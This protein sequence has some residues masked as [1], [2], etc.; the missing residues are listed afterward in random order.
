MQINFFRHLTDCPTLGFRAI[1]APPLL[2]ASSPSLVCPTKPSWLFPFLSTNLI[3]FANRE[4]SEIYRAKAI[5]A[6][7]RSR[8]NSCHS[9]PTTTPFLRSRSPA[10]PISHFRSKYK[11]NPAAQFISRFPSSFRLTRS[12]SRELQ[13]YFQPLSFSRVQ[14]HGWTFSKC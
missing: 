12:I 14:A 9:K 4:E 10:L 11:A 13:Q 6:H 2:P 3:D 1:F 5:C 7:C 8:S